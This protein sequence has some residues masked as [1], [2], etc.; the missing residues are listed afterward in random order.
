MGLTPI[1]VLA[2]SKAYTD[3]VALGDGAV[4]GPPGPAG[5]PGITPKIGENGSWWIGSIDTGVQAK[6]QDGVDGEPGPAG[7]DA[8]SFFESAVE[9]G[10]EGTFD[11]WLSSLFYSS[12]VRCS[13]VFANT[14]NVA[15]NNVVTLVP[16]FQNG[17]SN[18]I[19]GNKFVAPIAGLYILSTGGGAVNSTTGIRTL[20][21]AKNELKDVGFVDVPN[22]YGDISLPSNSV[23]IWLN[24]GD[25][26]IQHLY[27]ST[28]ITTIQ[29]QN[30]VRRFEF[31]LISALT[32]AGGG[33]ISALESRVTALEQ[34]IGTL[35]AA[36][37]AVLEGEEP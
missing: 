21:V 19:D 23:C 6:G 24:K 34:T 9:A 3:S 7:Q 27:T 32:G 25:F 13:G 31:A 20:I 2:I 15:A 11:E 12:L 17:N 18:M 14:G 30:R 36:L 5:Q 16:V 28:A 35:N 22:S 33:D 26:L 29:D 4:Q 10:F 37:Q 1:K 8:K